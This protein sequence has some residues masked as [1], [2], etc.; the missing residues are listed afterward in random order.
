MRNAF[1]D[2]IVDHRCLEALLEALA[3]SKDTQQ[4]Q[5]KQRVL[6]HELQSHFVAVVSV[7]NQRLL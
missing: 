2:V 5:A 7:C 1:D 4:M 6:I 3:A